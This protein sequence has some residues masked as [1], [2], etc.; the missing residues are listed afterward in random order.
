M[1][2]PLVPFSEGRATPKP[3]AFE[4]PTPGV[5]LRQFPLDSRAFNFSV[6][7][8]P[9]ERPKVVV[10]RNQSTDFIPECGTLSSKW[11]GINR[12]DISVNFRRNPF[13]QTTAVIFGLAALLFGI[14]LVRLKSTED[15]IPAIASY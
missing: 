14:L 13:V 6:S 2:T 7:L 5:S 4:I 1:D 11:D 8:S 12:L 15:L 10:I 3:L 9:A